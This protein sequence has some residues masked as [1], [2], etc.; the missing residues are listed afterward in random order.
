MKHIVVVFGTRPEVIKLAP[1]VFSLRARPEGCRVTLCSTGQHRTLLDAALADFDLQAD[2]DLDLM[3]PG[4]HPCDLLGRLMLGLRSTLTELKPDV[5]VVQ[6]DTT[7]VMAGAL[8]GFLCDCRVAHVEAGLRTRDKRAPFPEEVNRRVTGV[9]A[10]YHFVPT[11]SARD[12]LLGE[13]VDAESIY[14]TGNTIVD[15]LH[16]MRAR[17]GRRRLPVELDPG[18]KRLVLVTAHRRESFGTPLRELCEALRE[19]AERHDDVQLVYPVH[20]NPN[21][22]R[23]VREILEDCARVRL[24]EPLAYADFVAVLA[25]SYLV[26]TDSGGVQEEAPALGKPTLV[27]REKTER[28]EAVAAGVV[29]LV[30][31]NRERI[32]SEASRLLSDPQAYQAMARPV[33]VYGDGRAAP[34]ISEVLLDGRMTSGAFVAE[35]GARAPVPAAGD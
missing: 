30:G 5:V 8:A 18:G 29:R 14:L 32:V 26:L 6:G 28:P 24:V 3:Q 23:P 13:G 25:R 10:D 12:N 7:T 17:V 35:T 33:Q 21:V 15:A 31:T 11:A 22:Q 19:I 34:R 27:L 16:W 4:Q 9:V 20:L 1:V 2:L